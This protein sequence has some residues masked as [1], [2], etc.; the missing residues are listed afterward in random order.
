MKKSTR[1]AKEG[2]IVAFTRSNFSCEGVVITVRSETVMV[3]LQFEYAEMLGL[4][5][6]L[7]VVNHKN[8]R[9]LRKSSLSLRDRVS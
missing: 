7:T 2:D 3:E 5:N 8:Y 9:I 4:T 1:V 6:N